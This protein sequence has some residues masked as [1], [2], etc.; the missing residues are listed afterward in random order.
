MTDVTNREAR[1][2]V[3]GL[4]D[5]RCGY[6][7]SPQ[8]LVLGPL[9]FEHIVPRSKGGLDDESNLWLACRMCNNFKAAQTSA[10]DPQTGQD[11]NLFN[12]QQ[13]P[14][15]DHF[16][17]DDDGI[18]IMGITPCGRA[19]VVAL[20]LNNL[21]ATTVRRNWVQAGWHPPDLG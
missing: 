9:E 6:R 12:P 17:W 19:T 16:R 2:R 18:H 21:V 4:A 5:N 13:D 7:L 1:D 10:Y 15:L 20:Q 8:H 14:W 3:R 11:V